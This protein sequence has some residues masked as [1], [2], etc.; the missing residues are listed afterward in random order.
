M[1]DMH[2]V[3]TNVLVRF[4]TRDDPEQAARARV[5]ITSHA[6]WVPLTVLLETGWVLRR[7]YRLSMP[8]IAGTIRRLAGLPMVTLEHADRVAAALDLME[9]GLDM[10]DALHVA[11]A[12]GCTAFLT[13]DADLIRWAERTT[14]V[15]V[16]AP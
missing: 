7:S 13:F 9:K 16:R 10:A 2:A 6:I 5:A 12:A 14:G 1:N 8:D 11:G 3:D 15:A 4:L